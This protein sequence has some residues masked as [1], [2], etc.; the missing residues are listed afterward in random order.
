MS[1]CQKRILNVEQNSFCPLTFRCTGG[2]IQTATRTLQ[3]LAEKL[4]EKKTRKLH[5]IEELHKNQ[6]KLRAF[7]ELYTMLKECRLLRKVQF[8]DNSMSAIVE[9][10]RLR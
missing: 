8:I 10:G 7:Q 6:N 9:E 5:R 4:S 3:R 1:K 2:A